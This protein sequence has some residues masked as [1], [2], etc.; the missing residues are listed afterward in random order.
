M[1]ETKVAIGEAICHTGSSAATWYKTEKKINRRGKRGEQLHV[2][3]IKYSR[4]LM[5]KQKYLQYLF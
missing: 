1:N 5:L 3:D 4:R 2:T